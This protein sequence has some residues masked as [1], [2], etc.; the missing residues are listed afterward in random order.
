MAGSRSRR[1]ENTKS[2]AVSGIAV[3]PALLAQVEVIGQAVVAHRP[4][5]RDAGRELALGVIGQQPLEQVVDDVGLDHGLRLLRIERL[6]LARL[7]APV[8]VVGLRHG[9]GEREPGQQQTVNDSASSLADRRA[10]IMRR[11]ALAALL[12]LLSASAG[13]AS[14]ERVPTT[15]PA[16]APMSNWRPATTSTATPD[17]TARTPAC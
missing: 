10:N 3:R 15:T 2:S 7:A 6:R 17:S 12:A 9:R 13:L 5:G 4:G 14:A 8:D 11:L 1:N 16:S